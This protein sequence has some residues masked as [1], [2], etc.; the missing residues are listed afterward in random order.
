MKVTFP[1]NIKK[2][3]LAGMSLNIG[4]LSIS[5]VQMFLLAMGVWLS[6]AVF[7]WVQKTAWKAAWFLFASVI[8]IIFIVITFFKVSEM[9]LLQYLAKVVRNNFFDVQKKFQTN[10]EKLNKVDIILKESK[11]ESNKTVV[12]EHKNAPETEKIM[13]EIS[14]T[15]LI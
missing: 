3:L 9:N 1:K 8:L 7:N 11:I 13:K 2:W 14:E 6:L 12:I 5:I 10:S 4:P 15:E